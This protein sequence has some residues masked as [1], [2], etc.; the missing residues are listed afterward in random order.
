MIVILFAAALLLLISNGAWA[1]EQQVVTKGY[2]PVEFSDTLDDQATPGSLNG[3]DPGQVLFTVKPDLPGPP[4][5]SNSIFTV[6]PPIDYDYDEEVDAL[7]NYGDAYF[8]MI[9]QNTT[10]LLV[11]F[12]GDPGGAPDPNCVWYETP[13]GVRAL[14]WT[15]N[16][17]SN[18]PPTDPMFDDLDALETYGPG[19]TGDAN[20]ASFMGDP[21]GFSVYDWNGGAPAGWFPK[22]DVVA[23]ITNLGWS[24]NP[25][26]VDV[27]ALMTSHDVIIFSIR[28]S[29]NWDGGELVVMILGNPAVATFLQHGDNTNHGDGT[30]KW[31]TAFNIQAAFG[32]NTEEVDAIEA[33]DELQ[34]TIPSLTNWG[35]LVLLV[36]LVISGII[37]IR[38]R[39]RGVVR[40]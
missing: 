12:N 31:N 37:V 29:G 27:D 19:K 33:L 13:T 26:D 4:H 10:N 6:I 21:G 38:H 36:L 35:L 25:D 5:P 15:H 14:L 18:V 2:H 34:V 20:R 7:A 39:R 32:V 24:G 11:S 16:T 17:L 22:A 1:Q 8:T 9:M 23:A 28:A 40:A 30:N 3:P